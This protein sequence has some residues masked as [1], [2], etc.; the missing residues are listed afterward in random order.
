MSVEPVGCLPEA[1]DGSHPR[2]LQRRWWGAQLRDPS[3]RQGW[4]LTGPLRPAALPPCHAAGAGVAWSPDESL[5]AYV[6][7]APP[8]GKTPEWCG[9]APGPDGKKAEGAAAPKGWRGQGEWQEDWGEL[10][11][12]GLLVAVSVRCAALG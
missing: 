5:V 11:T 10:N 7:E 3:G 4:Q 8:P 9:A 2:R 12:G 6:A 1:H